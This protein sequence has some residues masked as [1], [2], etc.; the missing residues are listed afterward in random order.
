MLAPITMARRLWNVLESFIRATSYGS[1]VRIVEGKD[2]FDFAG[3]ER[4]LRQSN[5]DGF[6]D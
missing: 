4:D 5:L 6:G 1:P 3:G 2:A